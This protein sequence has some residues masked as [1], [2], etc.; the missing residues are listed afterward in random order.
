MPASC[1]YLQHIEL[2]EPIK[3]NRREPLVYY[4]IAN[5]YQ[6]IL[7]QLFDC[8]QYP[9]VL[10]VEVSGASGGP[11]FACV[12]RGTTPNGIRCTFVCLQHQ[13]N[14]PLWNEVFQRRLGTCW[15]ACST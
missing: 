10:V 1:R 4:R 9:N 12:T 6:F 13:G 5:H 3:R 8:F 11:L 14:N 7:R 2:V 15:T